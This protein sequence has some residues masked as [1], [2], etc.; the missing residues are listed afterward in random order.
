MTRKHFE[1]ITRAINVA[2]HNAENADERQGVISTMNHLIREF[3]VI[4][5]RFDAVRFWNACT[6]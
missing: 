5:P 2:Y 3:S 6:A 4:N 1:A